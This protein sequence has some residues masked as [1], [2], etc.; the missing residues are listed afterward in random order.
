M[1]H[2]CSHCALTIGS[3]PSGK[4]MKPSLAEA[5]VPRLTAFRR[6]P[7]RDGCCRGMVLGPGGLAA[8]QRGRT[9][10]RGLF[11]GVGLAGGVQAEPSAAA[12]NCLGY[13]RPGE[14]VG[15]MAMIAREPHSASVFAMRD[16]EVLKLPP[17]AVRSFG[18]RASGDDGAHRAHHADARARQRAKAIRAPILKSMR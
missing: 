16:S 1:S 10:G 9:A 11:P 8:A 15:E 18:A 3:Y 13:I 4:A 2:R 17:G 12:T 5:T 14:P 6:R 7:G